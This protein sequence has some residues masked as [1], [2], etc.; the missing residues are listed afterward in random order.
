MRLDPGEARWRL[1]TH[2]HGVLATLHPERGPDV[3]PVVYAVTEDGHVGIPV[4][5]VKPKSSSRLQREANLVADPRA[6]L[7]VE[8]GY[9]NTHTARQVDDELLVGLLL[10]TVFISMYLRP[11][12]A[13]EKSRKNPVYY[14]QYVHARTAGIRREAGDARP[15]LTLP[16]PAPEP[17]RPGFCATSRTM[18]RSTTLLRAAG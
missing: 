1:A 6:A 11:K 16:G 7:L 10:N 13:A 4:D 3:V 9:V 17:A 8:H 14:V 15:D 18:P 2:V 12:L 5:R